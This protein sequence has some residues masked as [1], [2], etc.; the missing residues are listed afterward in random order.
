MKLVG[1]IKLYLNENCSEVS[2][3]RHLSEKFPTQ[4]GLKQKEALQHRF[5]IHWDFL[6]SLFPTRIPTRGSD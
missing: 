6:L 5:R 1:L 4:N 3:G 2:I